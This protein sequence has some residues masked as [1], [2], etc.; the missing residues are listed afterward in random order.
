[1]VNKMYGGTKTEMERLLKDAQAFSGVKYNIDNLNDVYEAIHVVQTEMGITGT[2]A[3]E[4]EETISGSV[5]AM[6]SAYDNFVVG[7][8]DS[9]AN[10]EEMVNNL[11]DSAL[12]V[13]DNLI[14]IIEQVINSMITILPSVIDKIVEY[15][16]ELLNTGVVLLETLIY[17]LLSALPQLME[18]ALTIINTIVEKL[19]IMLPEI[20]AVGLELVA[21]LLMGIADS[22]PTLI[23][24]IIDAVLLI[25]DTFLDNIDLIIDSGIELL[26][27]LADGLI[28]ALPRL[29]D[30]IP[31]IIEKLLGALIRNYPKMLNAG[32]QLILQ[33]AGGLIKA[34][35]Q[36][37][38]KIPEIIK[39]VVS[40]FT[41]FNWIGVGG[42]I[43]KGI[44]NGIG[45]MANFA[46]DAAKNVAKNIFGGIKSFFGI[47]SP[48]TLMRDAIGK[49]IPQGLAVGIEADTDDAVD[50]IDDMNK[51]I[52][53]A[54]DPDLLNMMSGVP[55]LITQE[56][57]QQQS[58]NDNNSLSTKLNRLVEVF[59]NTLDKI[60]N[61]HYQMVLDSGVLV[62]E[63]RGDIDRALGDEQ[64]NKERGM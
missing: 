53:N 4:A 20:V 26:L 24:L 62:G 43:I 13:L 10:L 57:L 6:K 28:Q 61:P 1:M 41:S 60:A 35:P 58:Q 2:T 31:V 7:L 15:L 17:G 25:V 42:D 33:L 36:L 22:L 37:L 12:T 3:L 39:G 63:L 49:M 27:G 40:A 14:P 56:R 38:S 8:A 32:I 54:N 64:E 55:T 16:P 59:E 52:M 23:P 30:K 51:Q 34:I 50:A 11:L 29:I 21:S 45:K 9:N 5:N 46:V 18:S 44:G 48:S 47:K 19:I